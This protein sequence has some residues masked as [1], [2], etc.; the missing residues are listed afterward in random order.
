ML[1]VHHYERRPYLHRDQEG[2]F[3]IQTRH[4]SW[5]QVEAHLR[6]AGWQVDLFRVDD[7]TKLYCCF[8]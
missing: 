5:E 4:R 6:R 7:Q 8:L 1:I 2:V 3:R